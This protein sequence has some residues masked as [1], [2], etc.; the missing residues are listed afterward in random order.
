[1]TATKHEECSDQGCDPMDCAEPTIALDYGSCQ[2]CLQASRTAED[3]VS[4]FGLPT[5]I[6]DDADYFEAFKRSLL[7]TC[8][9]RKLI[10]RRQSCLDARV[11]TITIPFPYEAYRAFKN[12]L[13]GTTRAPS[14]FLHHARLNPEVE[15]F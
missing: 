9:A 15:G 13:P 10:Q 4:E 12:T 7:Q 3:E 11:N 2:E 1:M 8:D 6:N 14:R 5:S